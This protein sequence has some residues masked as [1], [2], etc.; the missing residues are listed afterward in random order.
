MERLLNIYMY[1]WMISC[2]LLKEPSFSKFSLNYDFFVKYYI[3]FKCTLQSQTL[4][5]ILLPMIFRL[6]RY[7][8]RLVLKI[9]ELDRI[10]RLLGFVSLWLFQTIWKVN[11][12]SNKTQE[13]IEAINQ[14]FLEIQTLFTS[15]INIC[16]RLIH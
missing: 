4:N 5:Q 16:N 1:I 15:F 12:P 2:F 14:K 8:L 9:F 10:W 3:C 7:R 11:L 6:I 13:K